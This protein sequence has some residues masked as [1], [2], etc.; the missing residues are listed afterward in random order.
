MLL[1]FD[2]GGRAAE[3]CLDFIGHREIAA[4]RRAPEQLFRRRLEPRLDWHARAA[5][6]SSRW[7]MRWLNSRS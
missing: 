4:L 3:F 2:R 1:S 5:R 6:A 7:S